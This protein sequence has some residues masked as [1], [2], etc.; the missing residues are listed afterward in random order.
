[1]EKREYEMRENVVAQNVYR[2]S[3]GLDFLLLSITAHTCT[4]LRASEDERSLLW[5]PESRQRLCEI[6]K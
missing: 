4:F 5:S 2:S 3:L 1:M 6:K